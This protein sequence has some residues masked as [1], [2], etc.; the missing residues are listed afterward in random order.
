[1]RGAQRTV[2]K[3]TTDAPATAR[4]NFLTSYFGLDLSRTMLSGLTMLRIMV[5]VRFELSEAR[6]ILTARARGLSLLDKALIGF[7]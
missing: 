6:S 3:Y 7:L 1:M 2:V 5:S 4:S